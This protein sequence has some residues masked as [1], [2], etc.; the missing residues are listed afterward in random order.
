MLSVLLLWKTQNGG[1][2]FRFG[3]FSQ[4]FQEGKLHPSS[5]GP[6]KDDQLSD[7]ESPFQEKKMAENWKSAKKC[8][9]SQQNVSTE[10][11]SQRRGKI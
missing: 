7:G 9:T 5:V 4:V 2:C 11:K 3:E 6:A 8:M 10:I 1:R